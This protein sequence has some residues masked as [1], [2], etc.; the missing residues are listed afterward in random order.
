MPCFLKGI[1]HPHKQNDL[2]HSQRTSIECDKYDLKES[3][4]HFTRNS[5]KGFDQTHFP[6]ANQLSN[7]LGGIPFWLSLELFN[8]PSYI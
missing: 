7:I 1:S 4:L 3:D 5:F 6:K 8:T 2:F